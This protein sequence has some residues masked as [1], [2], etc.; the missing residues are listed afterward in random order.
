MSEQSWVLKGIDPETREKA[1]AEAARRGVS[2]SDYLTDVVL[3]GALLEHMHAPQAQEP[4]QTEPTAQAPKENFVVRHRVEALER[5]LHLSVGGLDNAIHALDSSMFGLASRIDEVEVLAAD[6]ADNLEQSVNDVGVQLAALRKRIG[7]AEEQNGA[8]NEA[9]EHWGIQA[10]ERFEG[11]DQRIDGVEDAIRAAHTATAQVAVAHEALK[12]AVADDFSA[13][14]RETSDRLSASLEEVR[15]AAALAGEQ[16]DAA[17]AHLIIELRTVREALEDRVAEGVSETRA[18]MHAAFADAANRMASLSDRVEEAERHTLI[19]VDQLRTQLADVEDAS[20]TALEETA[21]SLRQAGAALAAEFARATRD[22]QVALDSVHGDLSSEIAELRERQ[23]GGFGRLKQIDAI[24]TT[25]TADIAALRDMVERSIAQ[26]EDDARAAIGEVRSEVSGQM[27]A[28]A[29]RMSHGE[30]VGAAGHRVLK[31]DLER[32]ETCTLAALEKLAKD[33]V[34]GV[35]SLERRLDQ[36]GLSTDGQI[37]HIRQRLDAFV[38]SQ[39]AFQN[40]A[41]ARFRLLDSAVSA[42]SELP[43]R[44]DRIEAGLGD[45]AI[46]HGFDA[47][48]LRLEALA[49]SENTEQA[50]A[51]LRGQIAGL[52]AQVEAGNQNEELA[53]SIEALRQ[54][55]IEANENAHNFTRLIG[56]LSTQHNETV[57]QADERLH[58]LELA[59]ADVRLENLA[60]D[61]TALVE[62]NQ[63]VAALEAR[64]AETLDVLR[65][66]IGIFITDNVRRLEMLE[67]TVDGGI[68][69]EVAAEF[70]ALRQRVE[71][72]IMGVEQRSVRALEQVADTMAVLEQRF[73]EELASANARTA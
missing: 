35:A 17:V 49:E 11:I 43:A 31:A 7:D 1:V 5:R 33:Q 70:K 13:F 2:L 8:L 72:R 50:L 67:Q 63:R 45:R 34:E 54:Q 10:H 41:L 28:L 9:H 23:A 47:R 40:G 37:E 51:A 69:D 65:Q 66:D 20:Q 56:H 6:T 42:T 27:S 14:T 57:K 29:E 61:A 64:H 59:V 32:V 39:E 48:L 30:L 26:S 12:Y 22:N 58:K 24:V 36:Q 25:T 71:D 68:A 15:A 3:Q 46:D 21:E 44:L 62:L 4:A 53:Q 55:T 16:A 52:A 19:S 73:S 38:E 60:I 18:K